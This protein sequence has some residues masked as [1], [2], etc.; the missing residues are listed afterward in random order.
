MQLRLLISA[1]TGTA[2]NLRCEIREAIIAF[3]AANYPDSLP[4]LRP[5][6][7]APGPQEDSLGKVRRTWRTARRPNSAPAPIADNRAPG[8]STPIGPARRPLRASA[9]SAR[10]PDTPPATI[11]APPPAKAA[12]PPRSDRHCG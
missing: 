5:V 3:V 10:Y 6:L 1:Q 12:S 2:F 9:P 4:R 7:D 8:T 11:V